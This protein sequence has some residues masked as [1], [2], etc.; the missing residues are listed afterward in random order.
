MEQLNTPLWNEILEFKIGS[1]DDALT[2]VDRLCRENNWGRAFAERC[3]GEY[4]KFV[5]LAMVSEQAV[6]WSS[7]NRHVQFG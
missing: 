3:V 2:F 5:Y 4:K 6:F 7:R 1:D